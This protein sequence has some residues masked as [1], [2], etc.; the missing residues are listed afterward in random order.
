MGGFG[1][2]LVVYKQANSAIK[3]ANK[4]GG[5][6]VQINQGESVKEKIKETLKN[7]F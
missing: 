6:V 1:I 3:R 7:M 5:I 4:V 2:S